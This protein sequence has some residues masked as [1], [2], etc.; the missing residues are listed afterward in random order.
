MT[1]H[2]ILAKYGLATDV[3]SIRERLTT[4]KA[5]ANVPNVDIQY[6]VDADLD[7]LCEM[8]EKVEKIQEVVD[9]WDKS[10]SSEDEPF[11]P[12]EAMEEIQRI[13]DGEK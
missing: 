13:L 9:Y 5:Y 8:A 11:E 2:E 3:K 10:L 4:A 7:L 6:L 12:I 1:P